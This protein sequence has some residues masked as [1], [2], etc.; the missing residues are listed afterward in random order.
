MVNVI[1]FMDGKLFIVL[2]C[3]ECTSRYSQK[4]CPGIWL[5]ENSLQLH[6]SCNCL[7]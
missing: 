3:K 4:G 5:A 1:W 6:P 7:R 2:N